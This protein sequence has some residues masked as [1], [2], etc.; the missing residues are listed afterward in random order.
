M[1]VAGIRLSGEPETHFHGNA[2]RKPGTPG[3]V[4][5][6]HDQGRL[7]TMHRKEKSQLEWRGLGG[8]FVLCL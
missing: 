5:R 4:A 8:R 2:Q 3:K 7:A 6:C 1:N